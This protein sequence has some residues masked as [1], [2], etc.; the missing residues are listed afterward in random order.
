MVLTGSGLWESENIVV[1]FTAEERIITSPT[2]DEL[3]HS[4]TAHGSIGELKRTIVRSCIGIYK[5]GKVH[6][7]G[8]P[9]PRKVVARIDIS[10]NGQTFTSSQ[11]SSNLPEFSYFEFPA[12][13]SVDQTL[14]ISGS[15]CLRIHCGAEF[16]DLCDTPHIR[17]EGEANE[18]KRNIDV[19]GKFIASEGESCTV[20]IPVPAVDG[21]LP[22]QCAVRVSPDGVSFSD[23]GPNI[24]I[25]DPRFTSISP[26]TMCSL[27]GQ[28][29]ISGLSLWN[30]P[31][32]TAL[33]K[34][35]NEDH[36]LEAT[37]DPE[38]GELVAIIPPISSVKGVVSAVIE[39]SFGNA[40]TSIPIT[41]YSLPPLTLIQPYHLS[42]GGTIAKIIIPPTEDPFSWSGLH[43]LG[44]AAEVR[45]AWDKE[46]PQKLTSKLHFAERAR[47]EGE[48]GDS[49]IEMYFAV[50]PLPEE[51][52]RSPGN[53]IST[54]VEVAFT[55]TE[56]AKIVPAGQLH[57]YESP[58][59]TKVDPKIVKD[60]N[61]TVRLRGEGLLDTGCIIVRLA[62][63]DAGSGEF[64]AAS[65]SYLDLDAQ[66]VDLGEA[67]PIRDGGIVE[68]ELVISFPS[69]PPEWLQG[70]VRL[71]GI[72]LDGATFSPADGPSLSIKFKRPSASA[73]K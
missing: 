51:V 48:V 4:S 38:N 12:I 43:S 32:M 8:V 39:A 21:V 52:E 56:K 33:I 68:Q 10:M 54:S 36:H 2:S 23:E 71:V 62:A 6:C 66:F 72:A 46:T 42:A 26:A 49:P 9:F 5:E 37:F 30:A 31:G 11:T 58:N 57:Y 28:A 63:G 1:R 34:I 45:L 69:S 27:G 47:K 15:G 16:K 19:I 24:T 44:L 50:P 14:L 3:G 41:V 7:R 64:D 55:E 40:V 59:I 22:L 65:Q 61:S 67:A 17:L 60:I 29:R 53:V 73:S 35:N 25:H 20:E 13:A 18:E 70:V